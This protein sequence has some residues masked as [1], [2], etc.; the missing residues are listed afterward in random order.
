MDTDIDHGLHLTHGDPW[1][2]SSDPGGWR[3]VT[4]PYQSFPGSSGLPPWYVLPSRTG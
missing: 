4:V 2:K 3:P 1:W